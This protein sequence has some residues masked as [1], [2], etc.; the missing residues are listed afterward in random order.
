MDEGKAQADMVIKLSPL[1]GDGRPRNIGR[2]GFFKVS[3]S[4]KEIGFSDVRIVF[5]A[6]EDG[7]LELVR[8]ERKDKGNDVIVENN[9]EGFGFK[10]LLRRFKFSD[11]GVED[12][13]LVFLNCKRF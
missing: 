7:V 6:H 8:G 1:A 2:A 5:K 10:L 3:I 11:W 13:S 4:G 12:G 9:V